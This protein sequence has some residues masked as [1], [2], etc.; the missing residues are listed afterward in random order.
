MTRAAANLF[1]PPACVACGA[2]VATICADCRCRLL[3]L[4]APHCTYCGQPLDPAGSVAHHC[5]VAGSD[6]RQVIVPYCYQ[7]PLDAII[8]AFKYSGYFALAEPLGDLLVAAWPR[9]LAPPQVIVPVPLHAHRLRERGFNQ[10]ALLARRL[11]RATGL[12]L[13]ERAVLRIKHTMPQVGLNP[14][15]RHHNV[16]GAFAADSARVRHRH[17]LLVDDVFTTGA[18]MHAAASSLVESGAATVSAYCLARTAG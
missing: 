11:A 2:P 9:W 8:H 12:P 13:D 10:S 6:L 7:D 15:E 18:T 17:I 16:S 5:L 14:D 1:L 4:P 3:P